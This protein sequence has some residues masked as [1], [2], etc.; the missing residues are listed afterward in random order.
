MVRNQHHVRVWRKDGTRFWIKNTVGTVK[1]AKSVMVWGCFSYNGVGNLYRIN[2]TMDAEKYKQILIHNV[3]PSVG[4]LFGDGH[5]IFQQDN[6]PKHT[7]KTLKT[8]FNNRGWNLLDWP[9]QSSDLNPI[10]HLWGS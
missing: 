1:H 8:Y 2:G 7:S 4:T 9:S 6:D 5:W 10:E 3:A